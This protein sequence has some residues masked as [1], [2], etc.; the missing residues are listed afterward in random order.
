M[1]VL[2]L[3]EECVKTEKTECGWCGATD[4]NLVVTSNGK[5][6]CEDWVACAER[7]LKRGSEKIPEPFQL[8][9]GRKVMPTASA[10]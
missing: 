3:Y 8:P 9:F 1:E 2:F 4:Q 10:L 6:A 5:V 7:E